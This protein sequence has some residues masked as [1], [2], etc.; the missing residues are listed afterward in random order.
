MA[1]LDLH[2]HS[3]AL[4]HLHGSV[5]AV[6]PGF[7]SPES[8]LHKH[9]VPKLAWPDRRLAFYPNPLPVLPSRCLLLLS[10][11]QLLIIL[12][13]VLGSSEPTDFLKGTSLIPSLISAFP[14]TFTVISMT[15][16]KFIIM[17]LFGDILLGSPQGWE[18]T[19]CPTLCPAPAP[20]TALGIN[21]RCSI[22]VWTMYTRSRIMN[23]KKAYQGR[24]D[25]VV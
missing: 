6:T 17:F 25:H 21:T 18:L 12:I 11:W 22:C 4:L 23:H 8:L 2:Y 24:D 1:S 5:W 13:S 15:W 20:P 16:W 9:L 19:G 3:I 10:C 14:S 7:G